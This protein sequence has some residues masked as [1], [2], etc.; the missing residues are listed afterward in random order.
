M[1][2]RIKFNFTDTVTPIEQEFVS[3]QMM[4]V[5][6]YGVPF[7]KQVKC[8]FE[9]SATLNTCTQSSL[10]LYSHDMQWGHRK[11]MFPL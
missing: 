7:G 10:L 11:Q 9:A 5:I 3:D 8:C 1:F 6:C 2:G 4:Y